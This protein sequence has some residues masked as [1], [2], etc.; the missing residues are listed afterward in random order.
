MLHVQDGNIS[1][2]GHGIH[3]LIEWVLLTARLKRALA[4]DSENKSY[5]VNALLTNGLISGCTLAD[6]GVEKYDEA[7]IASIVHSLMATLANPL[8]DDNDLDDEPAD[9]FD[10]SNV[11]DDDNEDEDDDDGDRMY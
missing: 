1:M 7:T 4:G 5:K 2:E 6:S 10:S 9:S 3:L 8:F 11:P